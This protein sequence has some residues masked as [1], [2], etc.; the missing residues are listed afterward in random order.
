MFI[1]GDRYAPLYCPIC[2]D[3]Y[4]QPNSAGEMCIR[5][6]DNTVSDESRQTCVPCE[7]G[8]YT[9]DCKT[10]VDKKECTEDNFAQLYTPCKNGKRTRRFV[11]VQPEKICEGGFTPSDEPEEVECE[12]C[13]AGMHRESGSDECVGCPSGKFY[14]PSS[15]ACVSAERGAIALNSMTFFSSESSGETELP[16]G[17]STFAFMSTFPNGTVNGWRS[18]NGFADCGPTIGSGRYVTVLEY[19]TTDVVSDVRVKFEYMSSDEA[20]LRGCQLQFFVNDRM[21]DYVSSSTSRDNTFEESRVIAIPRCEK[22]T[23][24]FLAYIWPFDV[25]KISL[26]DSDIKI[27]NVQISGLNNGVSKKELCPA[28]MQSNNEHTQCEECAAGTSNGVAGNIC[29]S[30]DEGTYTATAGEEVCQTCYPGTTSEK[31]TGSVRCVTSCVFNST[32]HE[33]NMTALAGRVIGPVTS[34]STNSTFYFSVCDGVMKRGSCNPSATDDEFMYVCSPGE[35]DER[36]NYGSELEFLDS[37]E[38]DTDTTVI[39]KYHVSARSNNIPACKGREIV[40]TV[41]FRCDPTASTG[42]PTLLPGDDCAPTFVWTSQY[43]CRVCNDTDYEEVISK[44]SRG[45]QTKEFYRKSSAMCNGVNHIYIGEQ[46]CTDVS[47]SVGVICGVLGLILILAGVIIFFVWK[48]RAI[49]VKYTKLLQSQ[50]GD[51][52]AMADEEA[53]AE[54]E[55]KEAAT[56][57]EI[58][59]TATF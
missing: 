49:T 44:C 3:G 55:R 22:L 46:S 6:T 37:A 45:S 11:K 40:T 36:V 7:D 16:F 59:T 35:G 31:F 10:C 47:L 43:A 5:C 56:A 34:A 15:D 27:R 29:I 1:Y 28:G 9:I 50:E 17:W 20:H 24:R 12:A 53:A 14:D 18:G 30:C 4:V 8:K 13:P 58:A 23:L 2:G 21:Y 57:S 42:F 38:E 41:I 33:Y 52:E 32:L 54:R 39:L 25:E 48:N 19:A 26:N 51:L